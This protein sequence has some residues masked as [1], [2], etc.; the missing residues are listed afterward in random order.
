M[1]AQ[2]AAEQADNADIVFI[3]RVIDSGPEGDPRGWWKRLSDWT[4]R[5]PAPMLVHDITTFQVDEALKG[6]PGENIAIRHIN[7]DYSATCGVSFRRGEA[8][9]ILAYR[10]HDGS[11]YSTSLCSMPQFS[12]DE[13]RAALAAQ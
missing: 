3:G 10:Q 5:R 8:I 12:V 13:F 7:G 4:L 11:G 9:L 2:S 6:D 1:R